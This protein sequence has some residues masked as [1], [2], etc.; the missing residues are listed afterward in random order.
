MYDYVVAFI[1]K[2]I[3]LP[4]ENIAFLKSELK[5][6]FPKIYDYKNNPITKKDVFLSFVLDKKGN[7]NYLHSYRFKCCI[8]ELSL[9]QV[10]K[11]D[12]G[13]ISRVSLFKENNINEEIKLVQEDLFF[14]EKEMI[15][16]INALHKNL[17]K[18]RKEMRKYRQYNRFSPY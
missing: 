17:R 14:E 11:D 18:E 12:F 6:E 4:Q 7:V 2:K 9:F 13:N 8:P 15:K 5:N 3:S 10:K 16:S 1:S